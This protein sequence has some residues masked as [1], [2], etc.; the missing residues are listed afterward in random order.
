M[1]EASVE[2][3][4]EK[5][6]DERP[7]HERFTVKLH[8]LLANLLEQ[9]GIDV[10]QID[11]RTKT[12]DSF[13]EKLRQK[14]RKYADPLADITDLTGLRVI[15]YYA[16]DVSKVGDLLHNEFTIDDS[17]SV[18][19][20]VGLAPDQFRYTSVHYV[21][22]L[23]P[24]RANLAEWKR[25]RNY[26]AEIQVRTALQHAWAAVEHKLN[27]KSAQDVP[28]ELQRQLFRLSALF[29][30]ADEEF[31]SLRRATDDL[32]A[33]YVEKIREGRLNLALSSASLDAY[34]KESPRIAQVRDLAIRVG[35]NILEGDSIDVKRATRDRNDLLRFLQSEGFQD[36]AGLDSLL[37]GESKTL[38]DHLRRILSIG[39][40]T[41][42][43]I[44][45]GTIDD[46]LTQLIMHIRKTTKEGYASVYNP[47][48]Y[49]EFRA[50]YLE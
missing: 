4:G 50:T 11:S 44:D 36:I 42:E 23:G 33:H 15:T 39:E 25:F 43:W 19:K 9:N 38:E 27:Y 47:S 13:I 48:T 16:E 30:L 18:D 8:D 35:W 41:E 31:S 24:T 3:W 6:R 29:E 12:V 17:R 7:L 37:R 22:S 20:L 21:L 28:P 5:Y 1:A 34:L 10:I 26:A 14:G 45:D 46:I 2:H 49:S 32:D 40:G